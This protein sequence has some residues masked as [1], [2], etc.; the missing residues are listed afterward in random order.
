MK[1]NP[2]I[3][4]LGSAAWLAFP[5]LAMSLLDP[6]TAFLLG[7]VFAFGMGRLMG[8]FS[9]GKLLLL[10]GGLI[11]AVCMTLFVIKPGIEENYFVQAFLPGTSPAVVLGWLHGKTGRIHWTGLLLVGILIAVTSTAPYAI[12][13]HRVK[14]ICNALTL[15]MA[16]AALRGQ[17]KPGYRHLL[18]LAPWVV[19]EVLSGQ[20]PDT[21]VVFQ[22]FP[23]G[24]FFS[25]LGYLLVSFLPGRQ[26]R[27]IGGGLALSAT[28]V[29][30]F[31]WFNS[32]MLSN[33]FS[34]NSDPYRV[35]FGSLVALNSIGDSPATYEK[36][37]VYVDMWSIFCG[38]CRP[39]FPEIE[40]LHREYEDHP[41]VAVVT[42]TSG[43][44]DKREKLEAFLA[45]KQF[46][47]PVMYDEK[48]LIAEHFQM[49]GVPVSFF[50][51]PDG[52]IVDYHGGFNA[53]L[54]DLYW[55]RVRERLREYSRRG[56][57]MR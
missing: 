12:G 48:S 29:Y 3:F 36:K 54:A 1:S 35:P 30:A 45:E 37:V 32:W 26:T 11:G 22:A 18:V 17:L 52:R 42:V 2:A 6:E 9:W 21:I 57:E 50:V 13:L 27:L 19:V 5:F 28:L 8:Q 56:V 41:G 15:V 38:A 33:S 24:F 14:V 43:R 25:L 4:F 51:L 46:D 34:Q 23:V 31:V 20:L 49:D 53:Q 16:A 40:K 39:M 55:K 7:T 10:A 47:F 44:Y